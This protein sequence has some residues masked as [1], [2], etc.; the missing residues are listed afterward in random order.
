MKSSPLLASLWLAALPP[1]LPTP[2]QARC[3]PQYVDGESRYSCTPDHWE[4]GPSGGPFR[5]H[6]RAQP[7]AWLAAQAR[8]SVEP[9]AA[10]QAQ[11][12]AA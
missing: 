12:V 9:S 4:R 11:A 8:A 6:F 2:A 10:A 3:L 7:P 1:L 5:C